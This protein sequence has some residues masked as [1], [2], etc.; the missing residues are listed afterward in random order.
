VEAWLL[1]VPFGLLLLVSGIWI[2]WDQSKRFGQ[3]DRLL[4]ILM[5]VIGFGMAG[6]G[7]VILYLPI[8]AIVFL[9]C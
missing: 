3:A 8:M 4:A 1:V 7:A 9:A 5:I 6:I 2:M